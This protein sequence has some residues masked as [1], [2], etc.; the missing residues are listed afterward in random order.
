RYGLSQNQY[1]DER[2]DIIRATEAAAKYLTDLHNVF[3]S[4]Y[5]AM[6]GYNA[7]ENRVLGG[8]MRAGTRDFWELVEKK[9]LPPETRDYVPKFLA[10]T[11]I[12]KNPK[13]Y[14]F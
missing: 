12:G 8:I 2:R 5:L 14:G 11:I 3:Q 10:A 4:W 6:A 1:V 13:K 7:G 9:A